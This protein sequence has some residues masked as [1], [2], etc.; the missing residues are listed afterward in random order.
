MSNI[1]DYIVWRGDLDFKIAPF[2]EVDNLLFSAIAYMDFQ[3]IVTGVDVDETIT[4]ADAIAEYKKRYPSADCEGLPIVQ[5]QLYDIVVAMSESVRF[6]NCRLTRYVYDADV[7]VQTQ[8]SVVTILINDGDSYIAF[9]GTDNTIVGWRENM[10]MMY[11][12]KTPGQIRA[13]EYVEK[14][15]PLLG[16]TI[17]IGGHS[18]GGNLAAYAAIH[19][20][21]ELQ[22][23]ISAVYSNDGPGFSASML[24]HADYGRMVDKIYTFVPQ[25]S[26][27]GVLLKHEE[28]FDVV[29]SSKKIGIAQHDIITWEVYGPS[30]IHE[31]GRTNESVLMDVSIKQWLDTVDETKKKQYVDSLFTVLDNAGITDFDDL[32]QANPITLTELIKGA[33]DLDEEG[34][35][36]LKE[37]TQLFLRLFRDNA[38]DMIK[39]N[40]SELIKK[41]GSDV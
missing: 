12:D 16:E 39:E 6:G 37:L 13:L 1:M 19:V 36:C 28:P 4:L 7:E 38:G 35:A 23:K 31:D 2:N 15:I 30:F 5:K 22:D 11:I 41:L 27:I 34:K 25:S 33:R 14:V 24:E 32:R 8:F 40:A 18:K 21:R 9:S 26:V 17:R 20:D 29:R 3:D 10:N